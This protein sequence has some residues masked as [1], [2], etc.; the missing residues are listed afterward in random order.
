MLFWVAVI[1]GVAVAYVALKKGFFPIWAVF[2]NTLISVYLGVML[3]GVIAAVIPNSRTLGYFYSCSMCMLAVAAIVFALLQVIASNY[4]SSG[5]AVSFPVIFDK[6][7]AVTLGFITGYVATCFVL[8][9]IGI[10]P[11]TAHRY[12]RGTLDADHLA[13]AVK[14][15]VTAT[16]TFIAKASMQIY[17]DAADDIIQDFAKQRGNFLGDAE[18]PEPPEEY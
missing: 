14:V 5:F 16:C 11:F 13:P 10:M 3:L 8:L 7:A 2:F 1:G 12:V 6:I 17:P 9:V 18:K 15:T 4:F